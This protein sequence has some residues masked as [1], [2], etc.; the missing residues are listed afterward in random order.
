MLL[1]RKSP[2]C[3]C[4]VKFGLRLFTLGEQ[5][6][7]TRGEM[8]FGIPKQ[9]I[10]WRKRSGGK[11]IGNQWRNRFGPGRKD[12]GSNPSFARDG[13]KKCGLATITFNERHRHVRAQL[14]RQ[15]GDDQAREPTTR[16]KIGPVFH[17]RWRKGPKLRRID[18]VST[19][20]ISKRRLRHKIY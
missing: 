9:G 20:S 6:H 2:S 12:A 18:E 16:A 3:V 8:P 17:R 19:P 1:Q 13:G 7:A 10:Q 11:N 14:K 15:D 5:R 4:V